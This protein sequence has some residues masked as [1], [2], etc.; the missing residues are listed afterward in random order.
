MM[1]VMVFFIGKEFIVVINFEILV[2]IDFLKIKFIV[3]KFGMFL[4]G[5]IFNRVIN[6]KIEFM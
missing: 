4:F 5:V 6:E 2:I 1:F 3:E